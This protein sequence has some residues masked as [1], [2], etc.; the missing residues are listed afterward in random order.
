MSKIIWIFLNFFSFHF[1][2]LLLKGCPIFDSSPLIQNKLFNNFSWVYWFLCKNLSKLYPP[3]ESSYFLDIN[4]SRKCMC[5]QR[6]LGKLYLFGDFLRSMSTT[7]KVYFKHQN[8]L[9][10]PSTLSKL[11]FLFTK[12]WHCYFDSKRFGLFWLSFGSF[13]SRHQNRLP[14]FC[15]QRLFVFIFIEVITPLKM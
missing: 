3:L 6:N 13:V 7:K 2:T 9:M 8:S 4:S 1:I 14:Q 12:L 11:S 15:E 10:A 5:Q